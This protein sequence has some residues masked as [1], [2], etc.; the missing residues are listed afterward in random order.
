MTEPTGNLTRQRLSEAY[1]GFIESYVKIA[2][3]TNDFIP[4][5]F[6]VYS[7]NDDPQAEPGAFPLNMDFAQDSERIDAVLN[8]VVMTYPPKHHTLEMILY[9]N[10][11]SNEH[12]G[13]QVVIFGARDLNG[14][15][16]HTILGQKET[17][18][19]FSL[20]M[21]QVEDFLF[22]T[23]LPPTPRKGARTDASNT[24]N[25]NDTL[26]RFLASKYAMAA[27]LAQLKK[28]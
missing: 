4:S 3:A 11:G 6:L 23:W 24:M 17:S 16:I 14:N 5:V 26:L 25:V 7:D 20:E 12:N 15:T 27:S 21:K 13:N 18:F 1:N 22:H 19:K 9:A 28:A 10:R 2:T 8:T